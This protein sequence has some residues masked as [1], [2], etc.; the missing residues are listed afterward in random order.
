MAEQEE[1]EVHRNGTDD[2]VQEDVI[3]S[4]MLDADWQ[5]V[6]KVPDRLRRAGAERQPREFLQLESTLE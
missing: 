3:G 1:A 5:L 2:E 4:I 6:G